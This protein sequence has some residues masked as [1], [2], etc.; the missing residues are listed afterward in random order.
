MFT[1]PDVMYLFAN[2]L[3]S[4][5]RCSLPAT[6]GFCCAPYSFPFWHHTP[7]DLNHSKRLICRIENLAINMPG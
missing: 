7:P 1:L 3:A 2:K 6:L 4:L 5:R